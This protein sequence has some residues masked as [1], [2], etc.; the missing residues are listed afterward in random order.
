MPRKNLEAYNFTNYNSYERP[1]FY[2]VQ[3]TIHMIMS[4]KLK[5]ETESF[6]FMQMFVTNLV[7]NHG[8]CSYLENGRMLWISWKNLYFMFEFN[9]EEEISL[10]KE[11]KNW[12]ERVENA[13][14]GNT[15]EDL[16]WGFKLTFIY[17][18]LK[19]KPPKKMQSSLST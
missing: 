2:L 6:G 3:I 15:Q 10:F 5:K 13:A 1:Q 7:I 19:D 9:Y 14:T 18:F 8:I 17:L 11:R 16:S 12:D 4:N